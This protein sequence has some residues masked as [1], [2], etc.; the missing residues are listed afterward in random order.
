[1]H[2]SNIEDRLKSLGIKL[3]WALTFSYGRALQ[4]TAMQ[5]WSG[6]SAKIDN[7]QQALLWR[8]KCN[9]SAALGKYSDAMEKQAA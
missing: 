5:T 7:A 6:D 9:G 1:M 4:Q 8:A 2:M 3:P